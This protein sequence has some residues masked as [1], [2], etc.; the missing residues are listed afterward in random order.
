MR[1][2]NLKE[3]DK[4]Y[5]LTY[6]KG[7]VIGT[8]VYIGSIR[9]EGYSRKVA[10]IV[11][12]QGPELSYDC[13]GYVIDRQEGSKRDLYKKKPLITSKQRLTQ[14]IE[15]AKSKSYEEGYKRGI[16]YFSKIQD[17]GV[18]N[19]TLCD[20]VVE[21]NMIGLFEIIK[22]KE[23]AEFYVGIAKSLVKA[24]QKGEIGNE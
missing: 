7:T 15:A 20:K 14:L 17:S 8:E 6:G 2:L 3:G 12:F 10:F 5:S 9:E 4:V 19:S 1:K 24:A 13:Y 21:I 16:E 18:L 11:Y 22:D 23:V